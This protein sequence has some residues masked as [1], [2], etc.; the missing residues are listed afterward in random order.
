MSYVEA[1]LRHETDPDK[2]VMGRLPFLDPHEL[3]NYLVSTGR[4]TIDAN[5]IKQL[6]SM[7]RSQQYCLHVLLLRKFWEHFRRLDCEWAVKHPADETAIPI[8]EPLFCKKNHIIFWG[9]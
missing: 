3:L 9:N 7:Q 8:S 5:E 4:V 6:S 2:T 1:P